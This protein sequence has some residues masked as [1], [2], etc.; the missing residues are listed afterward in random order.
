MLK[1]K[2]IPP[3]LQKNTKTW[4]NRYGY[5]FPFVSDMSK[6]FSL[7]PKII[8]SY[9]CS[10]G[11]ELLT[12]REFYPNASLIGVEINDEARNQAVS[13]CSHDKNIKL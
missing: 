4:K 12:L 10:T 13:N 3:T 1:L 8:V 11:D 5:L 2:L 6:A 7:S 9:G